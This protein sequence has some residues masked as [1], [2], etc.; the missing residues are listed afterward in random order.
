[1]KEIISPHILNHNI[2]FFQSLCDSLIQ[3]LYLSKIDYNIEKKY[4]ELLRLLFSK[5]SF[6][7][8]NFK[9]PKLYFDLPKFSVFSDTDILTIYSQIKS[10][11]KK[12]ENNKI[13]KNEIKNLKNY[14]F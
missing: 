13:L 5:N 11:G 9:F 6:P 3:I 2:T 10:I 14:K 12:L 7:D 4:P 1:M 8:I